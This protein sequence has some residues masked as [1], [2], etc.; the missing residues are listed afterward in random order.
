MKYLLHSLGIL[1]VTPLVVI[2]IW[3]LRNTVSTVEPTPL[4][5]DFSGDLLA[6]SDADMLAYGY[7]NGVTGKLADVADSV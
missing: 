1:L 6:A 7:A 2:G 4:V 5:A 3:N